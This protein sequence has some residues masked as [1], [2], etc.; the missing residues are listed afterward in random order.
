MSPASQSSVLERTT[1]QALQDL[2]LPT[3]KLL[4]LHEAFGKSLA[5][6]LA[7]HPHSARELPMLPSFIRRRPT[8]NETGAYLA[9]DLGGTNLRVSLVRLHGQGEWCV[10][11]QRAWVVR[12]E[13]KSGEGIDLFHWMAECIASFLSSCTKDDDE[14]ASI[15]HGSSSLSPPKEATDVPTMIPLGWTFSFPLDQTAL[16]NGKL[17][18][19]NKGFTC[20]GVVGK[21]VVKMLQHAL[22]QMAIPVRVV[23]IL[24]DTVG[25]L[26]ASGYKDPHTVI[27]AIFGTGTNVAYW[28]AGEEEGG[29]EAINT[30]WGAFDAQKAHHL[31]LTRY[32]RDLDA[33]TANPGDQIF[34]KMIS[35]LYLGE[36]VRLVLVHLVQ[37][38]GG[39][40][41]GVM[42]TP[43]GSGRPD[44]EKGEAMAKRTLIL[45]T[46]GSLGTA[47]VSMVILDDTPQ[48]TQVDT[49]LREVLGLE[50]SSSLR[51]RRVV[52]LVCEAV[53]RR[54]SRLGAMALR[55]I[56]PKTAPPAPPMEYMS[57]GGDGSVFEHL[58]GFR[59][60]MHDGIIEILGVEQG[61]RI[62]FDLAK[63]GSGIGAALAAALAVRP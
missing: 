30:E 19:W 52:R 59:S 8:G 29:V 1:H 54:A 5:T 24:N 57:V 22:H 23:A 26:L 42:S 3:P 16:D 27:G 11:S 20:P 35:G 41:L 49:W 47:A 53:A 50:G 56:L 18:M 32:D 51:D 4:Q 40:L 48:L 61:S 58:P 33:A 2:E 44:R 7:T 46:H 10:E 34:E 60:G 9:L 62:R 39:H 36:L 13:I 31:P 6:S 43:P 28:E 25:A 15:L 21:D 63:D 38:G 12:E 45:R 17:T 37:T 55:R 14:V